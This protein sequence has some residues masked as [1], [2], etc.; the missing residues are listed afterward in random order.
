MKKFTKLF[1]LAVAVVT[2]GLLA[3]SCL[4]IGDTKIRY[5]WESSQQGY[6]ESISASFTDVRHWYETVWKYYPSVPEELSHEPKWEGSTDIPNNIWSSNFKS[7]QYK[8][9]YL[10]ISE[11]K[12][13]AICTV[14]DPTYGDTYD[15]VANYQIKE[16]LYAGGDPS[17]TYYELSFDVKRFLNDDNMYNGDKW[18][19]LKE[20]DNPNTRPVLTKTPTSSKPFLKVFEDENVTYLVF[21]RPAKI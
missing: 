12:Y 1:L 21:R 5:T 16:Y 11:G 4:I 13:T 10:P 3:S 2:V 15:I 9:V 17:T 6:I 20:F 19:Y 8:G 7:A 14:N 18:W